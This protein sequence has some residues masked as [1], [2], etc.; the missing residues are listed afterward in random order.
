[1]IRPSREVDADAN[2]TWETGIVQQALQ[3]LLI[4]IEPVI[5]ASCADIPRGRCGGRNSIT[6]GY[7][8]DPWAMSR[9]AHNL[10]ASEVTNILE[11]FSDTEVQPYLWADD[12]HGGSE[13]ALIQWSNPS[14]LAWHLLYQHGSD[15]ERISPGSR[16]FV[17]S[18]PNGTETGVLRQHALRLNSSVSCENV[19][20]SEFPEVCAGSR[21]LSLEV[22]RNNVNV[23]I[24]V[25]GEIGRHP[26][27]LSRNRQDL[28]EEL[29]L[30]LQYAGEN[31]SW[32]NYPSVF[33]L[34]CTASTTRG[35]FE[36]GNWMNK[37]VYGPLLDQW[38]DER[39]IE[40][41]TNNFLR[42]GTRPAEM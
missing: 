35:Y 32:Y 41:E 16:Y 37:H 27:T 1:M 10:V 2:V 39:T 3:A 22:R 23:S 19:T 24:C 17:S 7:D 8:P 31:N 6:I 30:D 33:T 9:V 26:W 20:A 15:G 42:D 34:H 4:T 25:P 21:P 11:T 36:L 40:R 28:E 13:D 18:L 14:N 12:P 29:F 38:P 5:S